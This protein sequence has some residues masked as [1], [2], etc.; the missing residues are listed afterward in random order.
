MIKRKVKSWKNYVLVEKTAPDGYW[1]AEKVTFTV[2]LDG[3]VDQ[4][5]MYDRPTEVKVEKRK[6]REQKGDGEFKRCP[7]EDLMRLER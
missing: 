7:P 2:S 3:R 5:K 6:W 1:K 4:V